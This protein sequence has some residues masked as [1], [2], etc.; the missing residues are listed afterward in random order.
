MVI[1]DQIKERERERVRQLEL[2]DQEREAM[3]RQNADMKEVHYHLRHKRLRIRPWCWDR[4]HA[5]AMYVFATAFAQEEIRQLIE[6]KEAG[7]KLL[8]QVAASNAEQIELKKQQKD[9]NKNDDL[10]IQVSASAPCSPRTFSGNHPH[11]P[12]SL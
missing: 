1:I 11:N 2:Q 9:R 7:K 4:W 10:M 6:K 5:G 3:L 12:L 8:E